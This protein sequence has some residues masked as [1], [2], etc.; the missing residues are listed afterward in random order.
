MDDSQ[1][2]QEGMPSSGS[3]IVCC[4]EV[5]VA[6]LTGVVDALLPEESSSQN[7]L[8]VA[9]FKVCIKEAFSLTEVLEC[10]E[11]SL[12]STATSTEQCMIISL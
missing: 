8:L 5:R 4:R 1:E 6:A 11:F 3:R 9:G 2:H 12:T 10:K 7:E